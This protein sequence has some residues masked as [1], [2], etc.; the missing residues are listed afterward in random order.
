M[1]VDS[2][3]DRGRTKR[4]RRGWKRRGDRH[5]GADV[6]DHQAEAADRLR[7]GETLDFSPF[8]INRQ[9]LR[10]DSDLPVTPWSEVSEV[11]LRDGSLEVLVN[12][13]KVGA[14]FIQQVP[15]VFVLVTLAE[16][17]RLANR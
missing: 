1:P 2:P 3:P 15:N 9:G 17:L 14:R 12:G 11:R 4:G 7:R 16:E 10:L 6:P 8:A 13:R 5:R